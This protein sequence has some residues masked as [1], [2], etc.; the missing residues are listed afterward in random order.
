[1]WTGRQQ[2]PWQ[3]TIGRLQLAPLLRI[4]HLIL[5][6]DTT[7]CRLCLQYQKDCLINNNSHSNQSIPKTNV[8]VFVIECKYVLENQ[9]WQIIFRL[10]T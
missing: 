4:P 7:N 6:T 5:G 9:Y 2:V 10:S 8:V 1:M 3:D